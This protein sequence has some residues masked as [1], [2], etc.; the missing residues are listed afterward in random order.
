[1]YRDDPEYPGSAAVLFPFENKPNVFRNLEAPRL[2]EEAIRRG[3]AEIASGGALVAET[4][5]HTG[6]SP[7][8]KF[9]VRDAAHRGVDLVGQ[10]SRHDAGMLRSPAR[11]HDRPCERHGFVRARPPGRRRPASPAQGARLHGIRVAFPVHPQFAD[12]SV[13]GGDRRFRPGAYDSRLAVLSGRAGTARVPFADRDRRRFQPQD[14]ADRRHELRRRDQEGGVRLS[15][16]PSSAQ[17]RP[18]D[19]LLGQRR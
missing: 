3:E 6:R 17:A 1:M 13:K 15:Q 12:S 5:A 10:Q 11:R 9:I 19:A 2:Y 18:A 14:R 16:F 8:D 4:G 7:Q